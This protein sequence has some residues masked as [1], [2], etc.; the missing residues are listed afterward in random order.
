MILVLAALAQIVTLPSALDAR[1]AAALDSPPAAPAA[2]DR[3]HAYVPLRDAVVALNLRSGQIVWQRDLATTIAPSAGGDAVFVAVDGAVEALAASTGET[4]WRTPLPGRLTLVSWDTGWLLCASESGDLVALRA[5]DGERLWRAALGARAETRPEPALDRL[6]L[7]LEGARV[8]AIELATGR[9]VWERT[10]TGRLTGL[11][12]TAGQLVVGSTGREV[13]S[14]DLVSGRVRWRWRVGGDV[15]GRAASDERRIYFVARD[16][17]LRAVDRGNGNLRW[18][19][20]LS[21]RPAGGPALLGG[22]VLVP[23]ATTVEVFDPSD[24]KSIG[25]IPV[26][27][28]I[29]AP[30]Y[31]RLDARPTDTRLV[32]TT[33]DG[34]IQGFGVRYEPPVGPLAV[35]PGSPA[36]P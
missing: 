18:Y 8:V 15:T 2:F 23:L 3:E 9:L 29:A 11:S 35:L 17:V 30:P 22:A 28:E 21:A 4:T 31:V 12:A 10:L 1:W 7:G 6:Y 33:R 25:S 14:L 13:V 26:E 20:E 19:A 27:G 36:V 5:S 16:N 24:G 32:A 34:R